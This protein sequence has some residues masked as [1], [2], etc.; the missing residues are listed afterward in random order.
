ME[1]QI[2]QWE[3][4]FFENLQKNPVEW[5]QNAILGLEK[6]RFILV[7]NISNDSEIFLDS[8][9]DEKGHLVGIKLLKVFSGDTL[10]YSFE[11]SIKRSKTGM[12]KEVLEQFVDIVRYRT[13]VK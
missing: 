12:L 11:T 7:S 13:T 3:K 4:D 5:A 10:L 1:E 6:K 2:E 9:I 8:R